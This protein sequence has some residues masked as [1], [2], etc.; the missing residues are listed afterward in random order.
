[1]GT[2]EACV[3][4]V[5][6]SAAE[7]GHNLAWI[8]RWLLR[9]FTYKLTISSPRLT[10]KCNVSK[11]PIIPVSDIWGAMDKE[12]STSHLVQ[13][14]ADVI[15]GSGRS[16]STAIPPG[17]L[18]RF[19]PSLISMLICSNL[20]P[21]RQSGKSGGDPDARA[22]EIRKRRQEARILARQ[23]VPWNDSHIVRP[24]WTF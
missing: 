1:M 14:W 20:C 24:F 19:S 13:R 3:N 8:P 15:R 23:A 12:H 7:S 10:L 18:R 22:H 4:V 16:C 9:K 2:H 21:D 11:S 6:L 17:S 5:K